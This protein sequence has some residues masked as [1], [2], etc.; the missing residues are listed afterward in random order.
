MWSGLGV[1]LFSAVGV[2][3]SIGS[4]EPPLGEGIDVLNGTDAVDKAKPLRSK[5]QAITIFPRWDVSQPIPYFFAYEDEA[6]RENIRKSLRIL[7]DETCID[8][9]EGGTLPYYITFNYSETLN[10]Q[11]WIGRPEGPYG[12]RDVIIAKGCQDYVVHEVMHA[13]GVEHEQ[14][15]SDQSLYVDILWNNINESDYEWFRALSPLNSSNEDL[16]YDFGSIMHYYGTTFHKVGSSDNTTI[17]A[18]N[19]YYQETMGRRDT[20]SFKDVALLNRMYCAA[21]PSCGDLTLKAQKSPQT[22]SSPPTKVPNTDCNW[23]IGATDSASLS[24]TVTIPNVE[25]Y[26]TP[27]TCNS[28]VEIKADLQTPNGMI[29]TGPRLYKPG[30]YTFTSVSQELLVLY[31]VEKQVPYNYPGFTLTYVEA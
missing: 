19:P 20:P 14:R 17:R 6:W 30:N 11:S 12:S 31:H 13:L 2:L 27:I 22:L 23:I 5:R 15:R 8:F 1:V 16:P 26:W 28:Y 24:L 18:K 21:D 3:A 25:G 29:A 7:S 10:C 4:H 9:Q